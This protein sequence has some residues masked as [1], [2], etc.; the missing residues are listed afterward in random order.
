MSEDARGLALKAV[1]RLLAG[2][3]PGEGESMLA[4]RL[5][6]LDAF[7]QLGV[8][9]AEALGGWRARF[10]R[11]ARALE[12]VSTE[13]HACAVELL[14]RELASAAARA[15]RSD[16]VGRCDRFLAKLQALLETGSIGWHDRSAWVARLDDVVPATSGRAAPAYDG[17]EL[18]AV[19]VG[20][21]RRLGELRVSSAE[22]YD[23]CVI[24]RWH[25]VVDEDQDWRRDVALPDH[26]N[27]L[28][29][30]HGPHSLTDDLGTEYLPGVSG[31]FAHWSVLHLYQR[32][33]VLP[34]SSAFTP[35]PPPAAKRL[36]IGCA[37]GAVDLDLERAER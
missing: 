2:T 33:A 3:H 31:S 28:A 14:E 18:Q 9:D 25:L 12:P 36:S 23:D 10:E 22:L 1:E 32:P 8:L 6:M 20:P 13:V 15:E 4:Y 26:A 16:P 7:S 11:A 35:G 37:A 34:G 30:A 5:G 24:I 27:D 19:V 29:R 21:E 17:A